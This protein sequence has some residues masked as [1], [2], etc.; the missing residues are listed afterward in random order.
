MILRCLDGD[1]QKRPASALAVA[2]AL[3]GG[4][5]LAAA[6]AAGDT[7]TPGMVAAS[8]DTD[9]ISV[10]TAGICLAWILAGLAVLVIAGGGKTYILQT[11]PLPNSPEILAQKRARCSKVSA[12]LRLLFDRAYELRF[13]TAYQNYAAKQGNTAAY[14]ERLAKGQ[15]PLIYFWYRQSPQPMVASGLTPA[16]FHPRTRHPSS[17]G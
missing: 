17:P 4:D 8:A 2:A 14:R 6:L 9:G 1:P 16:M 5:P 15:P 3:P 7:P 12:T 10:R 13:D 11:T